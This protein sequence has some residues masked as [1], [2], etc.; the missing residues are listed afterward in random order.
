MPAEFLDIPYRGGFVGAEHHFALE[1]TDAR[2]SELPL[3]RL[4]PRDPDSPIYAGRGE[5]RGEHLD[6]IEAAL[7][8][9]GSPPG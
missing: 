8:A 9:R 4:W 7:R 5:H 3:D 2:V 6:E 1:Q